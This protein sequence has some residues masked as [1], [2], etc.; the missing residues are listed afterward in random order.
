MIELQW[1]TLGGKRRLEYR[2][3]K[4]YIDAAGAA[5]IG[6]PEW[7][8]WQTVPERKWSGKSKKRTNG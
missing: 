4:F 6:Q 1:V 5:N 7:G 2:Q 3:L 8:E